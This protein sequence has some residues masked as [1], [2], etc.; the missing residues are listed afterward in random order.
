MKIS[1][2]N[3]TFVLSDA[4]DADLLVAKEYAGFV[5]DSATAAWQ[6]SA[7]N[8]SKLRSNSLRLVSGLTVTE[9]ALERY[10]AAG[11]IVLDAVEAS[12][13]EDSDMFIPVPEGLSLLPFQRAGVAYAVKRAR[14]LIADEMGLG[15]TVQAIAT[16]NSTKAQQIL[17]VC[18]ASLKINWMR[19]FKKWTTKFLDVEIISGT[20]LYEFSQNVVIIN[21]DIL[22]SHREMLRQFNWDYIILDEV[23]YLKSKKADRTREVFGGIK[24]NSKKEIIDRVEAI[25]HHSVIMMTGTPLNKPKELWPMLQILDPHGLGADWFQYAKRYCGLFEI[26][27]WNQ[28]KQSKERIGWKWDGADNLEELQEIMRS[29][30]MVRRL[31]KDVL[32]ELPAKRRQVIV[33]EPKPALRKLIAK[34]MQTYDQYIVNAAADA[35]TYSLPAFEGISEIRKQIALKKVPY[36]IEHIQEVLNETEK[37]VVFAHHHEVLDALE[38]AFKN[39]AV[40]VDGRVNLVDR[41][42]AVDL[43]QTSGVC[44]VFIGGIQAAGVGLTLTAASTV[45]FAELDWT[46]GNISQAEDRCHRI[47]QKESVLVQHIVLEGSLDERIVEVILQKQAVI[48]VALD[49][50]KEKV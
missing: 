45:I 39:D 47:G 6:G 26:T 25:P 18:P 9:Q 24:R 33:L 28:D 29:R 27:R 41:Q 8:V 37:V 7:D 42:K 5:F 4:P 16:I 15:K 44:R 10:K 30:F 36:V 48:D 21:Y 1:W 43:F 19:E 34:E 14:V 22:Q 40:R 13:A 17:I 11:K 35:M 23:H 50:E 49:T 2:I 46:P 12:R 38:M 32:K 31:K 20:K 3:N